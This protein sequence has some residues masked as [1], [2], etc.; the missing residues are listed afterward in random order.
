M[1]HRRRV[2]GAEE[3]VAA[4]ALHYPLRHHLPNSHL[5]LTSPSTSRPGLSDARHSPFQRSQWEL[6]LPRRVHGRK[7][8]T[9]SYVTYMSHL[10]RR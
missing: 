8:D 5:L 7:T 10:R 9:S 1:G 4:T 6:L 3:M 2:A